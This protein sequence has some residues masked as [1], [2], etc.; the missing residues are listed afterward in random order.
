[1]KRKLLLII[2]LY[3]FQASLGQNINSALAKVKSVADAEAFIKAYPKAK[4]E[5]F[6]IDSSKH[7]SLIVQPL[8]AKKIGF[9]FTIAN[10]SYKTLD[11][12]ST[13]SF[14]VRYI[15]LNGAQLSK[16][17]IDSVRNEIITKYKNGTDFGDLVQQ[18]NMDGNITGDTGWF[19][20]GMMVKEFEEAVRSHKK[21]DI[22]S[23]DEPDQN[24]YHVVLKTHEST[25]VKKITMLKVTVG[26]R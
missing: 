3:C 5:I 26:T 22:F 6:T 13:L 7:F 25:Y 20:E 24:W 23:V 10:D 1:M 17:Q 11:K 4:G 8:Y 2:L 14:W 16:H 19:K 18:Y 21:G 9:S 15:F 12:D